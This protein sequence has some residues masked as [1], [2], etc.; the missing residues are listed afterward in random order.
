M[1]SSQPS[2]ARSATSVSSES[3]WTA[4]LSGESLI[5]GLLGR[6]LH[7]EP[8]RTWLQKL[9]DE[10][11]FAESP[12]GETQADV[13]AGLAALQ[14]WSRTWRDDA[15]SASFDE[16]RADYARLFMGPGRMLASPWES[17]YFNDERLVFQQQTLQ[18]RAWYRRYGLEAAH[19]NQEPDDHIGL[20]LLFLA[21]LAQRGLQALAQQ[22][23]IVFDDALEA[24]RAFLTEHLLRWAPQWCELVLT[25]TR[26][27]FSKGIALLTRG[28]LAELVAQLQLDAVQEIRR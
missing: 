22:D 13:R 11:V 24:Q 8:D 25:H 17:T 1:S 5:F 7:A 18:V 27:D 21:H 20:E 9:A 16:L 28:A 4:E 23:G 26:T 19:L 10:D 15:S 3:D 6:A 12:F 2:D 14:A